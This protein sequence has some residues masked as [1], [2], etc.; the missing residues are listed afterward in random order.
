MRN[1]SDEVARL[2]DEINDEL[3]PPGEVDALT[4]L[5][6]PL[7]FD[8]AVAAIE[9]ERAF[10]TTTGAPPPVVISFS[11][12][13]PRQELLPEKRHLFMPTLHESVGS[14]WLRLR[15]ERLRSAAHWCPC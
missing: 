6:P 7:T 1:G 8:S 11:H 5:A 2:V 13:L 9:S 14:D 10:A 4:S 15:V 12:F 3:P